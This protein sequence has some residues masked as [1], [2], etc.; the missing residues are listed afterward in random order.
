MRHFASSH[1]LEAI[2]I[3]HTQMFLFQNCQWCAPSECEGE[4]RPGPF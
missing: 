2:Q 1:D 3:I 4:K